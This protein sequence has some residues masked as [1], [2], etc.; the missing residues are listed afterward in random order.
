MR[1]GDV[2]KTFI[3]I[4]LATLSAAVG[5]TLLSHGMKKTGEIR[6]EEPSQWLELILSVVRNPY[7]FAGVLL[8]GIFFFL[9]L[10]AL[11][12]ADLSFV[13]PLT[14]MSYVFAAVLAKL[15]LE[16]DVSWYRWVGTAII[17]IGIVFVSFDTKQR[18]PDDRAAGNNRSE[19]ESGVH[20]RE[21][22]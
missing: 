17:T 21:W 22:R 4:L 16:E 8:L 20:Y 12:W 7:V 2:V 14:A 10:A 18:T 5:E 3:V 15:F 9:Y 13:M 6:L 11:S 1:R 19:S